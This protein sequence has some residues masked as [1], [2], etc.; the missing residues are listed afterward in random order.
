MGTG[1]IDLSGIRNVILDL[2]GVILE[3]DVDRTIRAFHALGFPPIE[4]SDIILS[5]YPFFLDFETGKISP[6]E[7]IAQVMGISADHVTRDRVVEAWNA[8]ILG[9]TAESIALLQDLR[10]SYRLFLLSNTNAIHEK[11]YNRQLNEQHGIAN[12]D[13]I[14]E[15]VYYSHRLKMRKPD[16]EIFKHVLRDSGLVPGESLYID[17]TLLHVETARSLGMQAYHLASPQRITDVL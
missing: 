12:L 1:S 5:R 8:M 2:G 9:F 17:D 10:Q 14:F 6:D 13:R 16:P 15:R 7:F 4:S 11:V 3:L